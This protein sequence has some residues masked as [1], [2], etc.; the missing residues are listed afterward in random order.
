MSGIEKELMEQEH[1]MIGC[2]DF[3]LLRQRL[4]H[5]ATGGTLK[6]V[7]H[8]LGIDGVKVKMNPQGNTIYEVCKEG[9]LSDYRLLQSLV[10]NQGEWSEEI[11]VEEHFKKTFEIF[12][13]TDINAYDYLWLQTLL[14]NMEYPE[15]KNTNALKDF[16]LE[17][18]LSNY[19]LD[20]ARKVRD[21]FEEGI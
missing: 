4:K 5:L 1:E 12:P 7:H 21:Y 10:W 9:N 11:D 6:F 2:I 8:T 3:T 15:F 16:I 17:K 20:I 18:L 19:S 13:D 14:P